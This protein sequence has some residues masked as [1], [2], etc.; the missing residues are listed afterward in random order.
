MLASACP[1]PLLLLHWENILALVSCITPFDLVL[2]LV[3]P[4]S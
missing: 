3:P 2:A 4:V 1:T